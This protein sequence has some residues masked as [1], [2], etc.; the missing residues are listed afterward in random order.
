MGIKRATALKL[1]QQLRQRAAGV[2]KRGNMRAL[3]QVGGKL[4]GGLGVLGRK[5]LGSGACAQLQASGLTEAA[6]GL[7]PMQ[8]L[9]MNDV[10]DFHRRRCELKKCFDARLKPGQDLIP[11]GGWYMP[12][13]T[14][15][16]EEVPELCCVA[17]S[18]VQ[19]MDAMS[20]SSW[21]I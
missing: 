15:P 16:H 21:P 19:R 18:L 5:V 4:L 12:C 17:A 2:F 3:L 13:R 20:C 11:F 14:M 7:Y 8:P 10:L 9:M 1:Y 6:R